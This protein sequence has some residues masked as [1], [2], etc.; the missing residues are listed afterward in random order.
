MIRVRG[1]RYSHFGD[2]FRFVNVRSESVNEQFVSVT[3]EYNN[4]YNNS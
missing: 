1:S 3:A 2:I 4:Q